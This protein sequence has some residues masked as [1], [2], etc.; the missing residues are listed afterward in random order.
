ME[1]DYAKEWLPASVAS[2]LN[3]FIKVT[4]WHIFDENEMLEKWLEVVVFL[5]SGKLVDLMVGSDLWELLMA[6]CI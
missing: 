2:L 3:S 5:F 6:G 1:F 4:R